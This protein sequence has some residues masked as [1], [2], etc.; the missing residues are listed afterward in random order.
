MDWN[1]SLP[2]VGGSADHEC[3]YS[4][5]HSHSRF[6]FSF[7]FSNSPEGSEKIPSRSPLPGGPRG[8]LPPCSSCKIMFDSNENQQFNS[9]NF[10]A[11]QIGMRLIPKQ[12]KPFKEVYFKL[13]SRSQDTEIL[14]WLTQELKLSSSQGRQ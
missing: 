4:S 2:L 11:G 10:L 5:D 3:Q 9:N 7:F 1:Y 8:W 14:T 12:N 13:G 6:S